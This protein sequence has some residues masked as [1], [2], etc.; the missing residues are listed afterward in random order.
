M[1]NASANAIL[2]KG[3]AQAGFYGQLGDLG[4]KAA[5]AYFTGGMG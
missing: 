2:N 3:Q 4:K 5:M 1:G